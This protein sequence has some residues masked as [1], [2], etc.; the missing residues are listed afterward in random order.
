MSQ[1]PPAPLFQLVANDSRD[2]KTI[3]TTITT[4]LKGGLNCDCLVMYCSPTEFI[5]HGIVDRSWVYL[6]TID[7][8]TFSHYRCCESLMNTTM[9]LPAANAGAPGAPLEPSKPY[10]KMVVNAK[11][12]LKNIGK[13]SPGDELELLL[14][15]QD[16]FVVKYRNAEIGE[17]EETLGLT[18]TDEYEPLEDWNLASAGSIEFA[19]SS[20]KRLV[21]RDMMD[22]ENLDIEVKSDDSVTMVRTK[23]K[24]IGGR[25]ARWLIPPSLAAVV[26]DTHLTHTLKLKSDSTL[27]AATKMITEMTDSFKILLPVR[28]GCSVKFQGN[29]ASLACVATVMIGQL[30]EF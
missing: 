19:T 2:L 11:E 12:L 25:P 16:T 22:C 18:S 29:V 20:F 23:K 21:Q 30:E 8:S 17:K 24:E 3:L 14:E 13:L 7:P 26:N 9:K 27:D 28:E 15:G 5:L 1:S 4:R 6:V 10:F